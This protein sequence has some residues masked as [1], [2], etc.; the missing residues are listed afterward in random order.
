MFG[1]NC[2][3]KCNLVEIDAEIGQSVKFR[4]TSTTQNLNSSSAI[5]VDIFG[6]PTWNDNGT[7]YAKVDDSDL[8]IN[9]AGRYEVN[10][11]LSLTSPASTRV[12]IDVQITINDTPVGTIASSAYIRNTG[13][14]NNSSINFTETLELNANDQLS[15]IATAEANISNA[16]G[17]YRIELR[18][19]GT[20]NITITKL[21]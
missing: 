19:V 1:K 17:P 6:N 3:T 9:S 4:N 5:E 11:N 15:I 20:S 14:H 10:V 7:L 18:D 8:S 21:R 13:N 12:N 16:L 2:S